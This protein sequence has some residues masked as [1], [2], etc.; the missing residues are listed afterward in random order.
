MT[1]QNDF[2]NY[3]DEGHLYNNL[4]IGFFAGAGALAVVTTV[5]FVVDAK[6]PVKSMKAMNLAPTIGNKQAGVSL[7][8][9]F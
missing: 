4:G 1:A 8:W 9:S 2:N 7:G 6:R 5:L 3:R